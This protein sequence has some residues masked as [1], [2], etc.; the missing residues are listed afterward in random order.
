MKTIQSAWKNPISRIAIMVAS[1]FIFVCCCL[2]FTIVSGDDSGSQLDTLEPASGTTASTA[3]TP[4]SETV[5][6]LETL[7]PTI[8]PEPTNTLPPTEELEIQIKDVLGEGNRDVPRLTTYAW[9]EGA[10]D[11]F[12]QFAINDNILDS[13][14]VSGIQSDIVD[15]LKTVD[16]SGLVPNYKNIT[17]SGTFVLVDKFGNESEDIVV[18]MFYYRA[19][20]DK[21]NWDNFIFTNIFDIADQRFIHPALQELINDSN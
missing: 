11:L 4:V 16:Q 10:Q 14:I 21:I 19:T 3:S 9:D 5:T 15:I 2:F 1:A 7:V 8:T 13:F 17:V 12:V 6:L 18:T 20:V